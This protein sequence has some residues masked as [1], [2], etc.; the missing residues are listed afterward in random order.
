[1]TVAMDYIEIR[2][3]GIN[4]KVPAF[5]ISD[6]TVM[7]T[8]RWLK[9]ASV[10]DEEW[11]EGEVLP[12]P[13]QFI[14]ELR[15]HKRLGAD[16][17]TFSQKPNDPTPRFPFYYD[18]DSIAAVP[19]ISYSDWW[20]KRV[21]TRLRQDV[22]KAAKLGVVVRSVPFT[23]DLVRG[24]ADI[25]NET[26]IR[27]GRRF[28]HYKKGLEAVK[29][30]NG[31]YLE[32]SEFLG[33][34][35]GDEL[36]GFI[37]IVYADRLARLMQILSKE[38]HRDKRPTTALIAKAVEICEAK[39]CSHLIYGNYHYLQGADSLTMFKHRNGFE[40]ILV[41]KYYVPLTMKG[42]LSLRLH[43]Q[44]GVRGLVPASVLQSF[45]RARAAIY[46]RSRVVEV[47]N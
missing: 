1:M 8:G 21:S 2:V 5:Q 20:T 23:D 39:A 4:R 35:A 19:V 46:R 27:Q 29:L 9:F 10:H 24:I 15:R 40:E 34:F 36:I 16:I 31:T 45:R 17:F 13:E 18:W 33:A 11:Q 22:R 32:R 7:V 30:E 3:A 14:A 38:A 26:P 25:Y 37:K 44:H 43:L 12:N 47:A 28:W 42:S 41:P 6:A